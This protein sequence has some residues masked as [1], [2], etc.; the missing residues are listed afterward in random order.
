MGLSTAPQHSLHVPALKLQSIQQGMKPGAQQHKPSHS[1][2]LLPLLQGNHL[3]KERDKPTLNVKV[4]FVNY[5]QISKPGIISNRQATLKFRICG[6][7]EGGNVEWFLV[8]FI[9][10]Y[11]HVI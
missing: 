10:C 8:T 1:Q 11:V 3:G 6:S 4:L 9:S 7:G 5:F 2:P